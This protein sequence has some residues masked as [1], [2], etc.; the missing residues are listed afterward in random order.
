M[1]IT[2]LGEKVQLSKTTSGKVVL[3]S[4]LHTVIH[5]F[6]LRLSALTTI[7]SPKVGQFAGSACFSHHW[8]HW[9]ELTPSCSSALLLLASTGR[10][11]RL[12]EVVCRVLPHRR[13]S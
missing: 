7:L 6:V 10:L 12:L 1:L 2:H 13:R 4:A 11:V 3:K 8:R 5:W 9:E